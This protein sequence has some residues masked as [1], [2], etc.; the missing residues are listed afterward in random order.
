MAT[1]AKQNKL[2]C[3]DYQGAKEVTYIITFQL[4]PDKVQ[5]FLAL[6]RPYRQAFWN[7]LPDLLNAQ[8]SLETWLPMQVDFS[9]GQNASRRTTTSKSGGSQEA[10][11]I[12][13]T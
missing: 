4:K 8:R 11:L 5:D 10:K 7:A 2:H 1:T 3:V 6:L 13:R 9:L 12:I